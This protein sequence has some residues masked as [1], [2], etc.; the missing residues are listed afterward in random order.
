MEKQR[1]KT[2][3]ASELCAAAGIKPNT[4]RT[5]RAR[6]R[7]QGFLAVDK[8]HARE[9]THYTESDALQVIMLAALIRNGIEPGVA[10]VVIV[11]YADDFSPAVWRSLRAGEPKF[12]TLSMLDPDPRAALVV[13]SGSPPVLSASEFDDDA[14]TIVI[15]LAKLYRR[16]KRALES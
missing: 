13:V 16:A 9:W 11:E 15:D 6:W 1:P 3:V 5:W 8:E 14:V 10:V 4:L 7:D 12:V 2:Y